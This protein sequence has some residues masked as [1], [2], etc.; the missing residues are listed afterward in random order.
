[1]SIWQKAG[2]QNLLKIICGPDSTVYTVPT[3]PSDP[4][5]FDLNLTEA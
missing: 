4:I 2:T 3:V 1:M 5:Y